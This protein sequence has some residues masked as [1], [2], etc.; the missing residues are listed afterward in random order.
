MNSI[1]TR[2]DLGLLLL[3]VVAGFSF[4]MHG[5]QKVF[6][7]GLGPV[8]EG[9]S[10]MGIP[11][12]GLMGPAISLLELVG[13]IALILGVGTRIVAFLLTCDMIGAILL[14]HMKNGFFAPNGIE[15]ALLFGAM[16]GAL[17]LT[18]AG[19]LSI[20]AKIAKGR[21]NP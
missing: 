14:V 3:R 13:G 21:A 19:E 16:C 18:G 8:T 11:L 7:M 9:F 1:R 10:K 5:Y 15:L 12:P 4:A 2:P 6:T 17:V 20:D